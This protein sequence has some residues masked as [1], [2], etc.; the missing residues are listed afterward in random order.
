MQDERDIGWVNRSAVGFHGFASRNDAAL[1]ASLAQVALTRRRKEAAR[2]TGDPTDILVLSH[3]STELVVAR[4]EIL[5]RLLPPSPENP[6]FGW[7]FEVE[8]FP[9]EAFEVFAIGRARVMWRAIQDRF[10]SKMNR[11]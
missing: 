7:G 6:E 8:L 10:G 11:A 4:S 2:P 1:A 3:G 9:D 5:A